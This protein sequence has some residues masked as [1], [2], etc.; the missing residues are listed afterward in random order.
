MVQNAS[1]YIFIVIVYTPVVIL[2]H[3]YHRYCMTDEDP[4]V[5]NILF[6]FPSQS[7]RFSQYMF[8]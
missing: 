2:M 4:S 6:L 3:N 7:S 5:G 1:E 8:L